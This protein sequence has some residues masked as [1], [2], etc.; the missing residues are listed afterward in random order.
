MPPVTGTLDDFSVGA[1]QNLTARTGWFSTSAGAGVSLNTDAVPTYCKH[2]GGAS[3]AVNFWATQ[4]AADQEAWATFKS[5]PTAVNSVT[6]LWIRSG[7]PN[8]ITDG[9]ICRVTW[10]A[11]FVQ[12]NRIAGGSTV[13]GTGSAPAAFAVGDQILL[14]A[15]GTTITF[16]YN[17]ASGGG[18]TNL[19]TVSD[20][21]TNAAGYIGIYIPATAADSQIDDF[22]GG[23]YTVGD[24]STPARSVMRRS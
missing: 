5:P 15:V 24:N 11:G 23:G 21:S 12:M 2:P 3:D 4:F 14:R 18:W 13:I 17:L 16:D 8:T 7:A 9:Y 20:G 6:R 22:G 19:I 10:S 1:N